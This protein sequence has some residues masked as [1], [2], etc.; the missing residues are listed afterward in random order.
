[1]SGF[2]K[3]STTR[4]II[5]IVL[6]IIYGCILVYFLF[7]AENMGRSATRD[8]SLNLI[9]FHE[10]KRFLTNQNKLG[11]NAVWMNIAGNVAAFIPFGL[12]I[13]PVM[14]R[15][16]GFLE[17]AI[18]TFDIS[19]CVELIQLVTKVGSFDVDDLILN[20]IGGLIGAGIYVTHI[21][22]ERNSANGKVQI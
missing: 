19:L 12:F 11:S 1:M 5:S 4:R 8:Y 21:R 15:N 14:G 7:F 22:I 10:I 20:T 13:I 2:F 3:D 17:A 16:I 6:F 18:M 9:P